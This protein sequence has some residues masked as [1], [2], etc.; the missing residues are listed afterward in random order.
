MKFADIFGIEDSNIQPMSSAVRIPW[1]LKQ[2]VD[3]RT[4]NM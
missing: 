3:P 1:W 4:L 2:C